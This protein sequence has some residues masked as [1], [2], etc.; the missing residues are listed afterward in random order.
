MINKTSTLHVN[1]IRKV[2]HCRTEQMALTYEG[3]IN[4]YVHK[5]F[6]RT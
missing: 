6:F 3:K 2:M 5:T 4:S 1:E